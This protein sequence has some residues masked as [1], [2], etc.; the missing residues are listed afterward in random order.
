MG[1]QSQIVRSSEWLGENVRDVIRRGYTCCLYLPV[2][3]QFSDVMIFDSNVFDSRM[4][5]L[6]F[7][8]DRRGVVVAMDRCGMRGEKVDSLE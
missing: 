6:I 4:P 3:Y 2:G 8:K 7:G 5:N 1:A